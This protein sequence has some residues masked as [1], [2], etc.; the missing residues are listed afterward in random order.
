MGS[1]FRKLD[2]PKLLPVVE[3]EEHAVVVEEEEDVKKRRAAKAQTTGRS[4]NILSGIQTVL[5]QR[6]GE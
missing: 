1:V 5:K 3:Q 4:Q 2:K 6:L